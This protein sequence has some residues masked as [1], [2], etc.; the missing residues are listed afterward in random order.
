[1]KNLAG[2]S[3]KRTIIISIT[4][5]LT[6]L[7]W[8]CS[9]SSFSLSFKFVITLW[10]SL[11]VISIS[12]PSPKRSIWVW[13]LAGNAKHYNVSDCR[14]R[15]FINQTVNNNLCSATNLVLGRRRKLGAVKRFP[16]SQPNIPHISAFTEPSYKSWSARDKHKLG[17]MLCGRRSCIY[18][19]SRPLQFCK[20]ITSCN[21]EKK[22]RVY[23]KQTKLTKGIFVL[24]KTGEKTPQLG[25][26]SVIIC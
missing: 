26:V 16:L 15:Q 21:S 4:G 3:P 12:V 6:S 18:V 1:M 7:S 10:E 17:C 19:G 9:S 8:S 14:Y 5:W 20:S 23:P 24:I 11:K 13:D 2:N 25:V 22:T